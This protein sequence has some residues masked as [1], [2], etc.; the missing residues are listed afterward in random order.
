MNEILTKIQ[1]LVDDMSLHKYSNLAAW[2]CKLDAEIE[3]KLAARLEAGLK[4][5]TIAVAS[6]SE[7]LMILVF[8][9]AWVEALVSESEDAERK[10]DLLEMDTDA[11]AKLTHKLGGEPKF[12]VGRCFLI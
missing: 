1:K 9:A 5:R 10:Q 2:V 8:A 4:G 12:K 3:K 7:R 11:P 6:R